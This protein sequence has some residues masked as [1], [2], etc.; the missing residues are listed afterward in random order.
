VHTA[1][2]G[3]LVVDDDDDAAL[4]L[5]TLLRFDGH[6]TQVARDGREALQMAELFRPDVVVLDVTPPRVF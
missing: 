2:R 6:E 5:A 1:P 4:S 3:I